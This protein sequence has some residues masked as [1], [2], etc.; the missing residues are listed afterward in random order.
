MLL[1]PKASRLT[2]RQRA[3]VAWTAMGLSS[4]DIAKRMG[5]TGQRVRSMLTAVEMRLRRHTP[6][7]ADPDTIATDHSPMPTL[8]WDGLLESLTGQSPANQ[9]N[10]HAD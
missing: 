3:A 5:V 1:H 6:R 8:R 9:E 10:R 2:V 7:P 4:R